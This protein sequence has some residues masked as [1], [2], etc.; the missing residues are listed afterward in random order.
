MKESITRV[1]IS[2]FPGIGKSRA[3]ASRKDT[4]DLD[5]SQ[6]AGYHWEELY[7]AAIKKAYES[8]DYRIIFISSHSNV[9]EL[10]HEKGIPFICVVPNKSLRNEYMIRY[11]KRGSSIAFMQNIRVNW[12]DWIDRM[13][14]TELCIELQSGEYVSDILPLE[15]WA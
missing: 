4:L 11:L 8:G 13:R 9:R 12:N 3:A 14:N 5:S 10:L 1:I 2:G 15:C 6:F 7:V